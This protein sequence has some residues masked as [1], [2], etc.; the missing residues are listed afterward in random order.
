MVMIHAIIMQLTTRMLSYGHFLFCTQTI[1]VILY[2]MFLLINTNWSSY[3]MATQSVN[4]NS[5]LLCQYNSR[6]NY[7]Q[8][9]ILVNK[10]ISVNWISL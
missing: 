4:G 6:F 8:L 5:V 10:N 9:L 1:I 3:T 7:D 2:C